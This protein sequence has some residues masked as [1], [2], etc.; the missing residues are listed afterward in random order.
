MAGVV[1]FACLSL[2]PAL[3]L[4]PQP[5]GTVV[6]DLHARQLWWLGTVVATAIGL[7]LLIGPRRSRLQR[8]AGI[9][10]V[11]VPHLLGAPVADGLSAVPIALAHRFAVVSVASSAVFWLMVGAI[12]GYCAERQWV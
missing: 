12:G 6:A 5:P 9:A 2:A 4:P 10:I 3:G 8:G 1:A 7:W 11:L